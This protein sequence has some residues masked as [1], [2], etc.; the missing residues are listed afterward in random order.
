MKISKILLSAAILVFTTGAT[1]AANLNFTYTSDTDGI[2]GYFSVDESAFYAHVDSPYSGY[3]QNNYINDF[4]FTFRGYSWDIGDVAL[5]DQTN[6]DH[7]NGLSLPQVLGGNGSLA[8]TPDHF[9]SIVLFGGGMAFFADTPL[10]GHWS[11]SRAA[12]PV[13]VPTAAWLL[14]SGLLGL[15]GVARHKTA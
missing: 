7:N 4:N 1:H 10:S 6:F 2:L 8:S 11:T 3:L 15:I 14:G 5:K 12:T 9:W 13:P